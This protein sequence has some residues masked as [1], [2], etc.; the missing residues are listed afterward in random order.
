M[1]NIYL[2]RLVKKSHFS[3]FIAKSQRHTNVD[4]DDIA[5]AYYNL[6][7]Y[8]TVSSFSIHKLRYRG[9]VAKVISLALCGKLI[10]A[11]NTLNYLVKHYKYNKL[12]LLLVER[13]IPYIPQRALQLSEGKNI[14]L[15]LYVSLLIRLGRIDQARTLLEIAL[16]KK[17]YRKHPEILL[18]FLNISKNIEPK[19]Q[20]TFINKY[21]LAFDIPKVVLKDK[22]KPFSTLNVDCHATQKSSGPLITIIMTAYNTS[23]RTSIA[24][25]SILKQ[26]YQ[27][28]ELIIVDDESTD[29]TQKIIQE[30]ERK[31]KRVKLIHLAQ[32]VGTYV[33]KNIALLQA[34][35]EFIT[36]HDSDDWSHPL[37]IERQ[38]RPLIRYSRLV[39]TMSSLIRVD[40][41]GEFY[42]R[43]VHPL[44]RQNPS[45]LM[46]RKDI[47]LKKV[48]IWDSERTGADSEFVARLK[49]VLGRKNVKR[50]KEPLSFASH[51]AD[52]LMT[53]SDTGYCDLGM[54]PHRLE[55]W[56]A[57][58]QWHIDELAKD[59]KPFISTDFLGEGKFG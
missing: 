7:M 37:K 46:F 41:N 14:P 4:V 33:A 25:E 50:I 17:E 8:K 36:C 51:R 5:W 59:K 31:D 40:D 44:I 47:V 2:K 49:L 52:S 42:A 34:K 27:N 15:T 39:A 12:Y 9:L 26:T 32:N 35:G 53:A 58:A 43:S 29:D 20:L 54:A 1:Y 10:D 56:E 6:G 57:W 28:L 11:E 45:S 18:Y 22:T 24:I 21:L 23:H 19:Q 16:K 48:G 38:A 30:W 55:Y 13:L 3:L